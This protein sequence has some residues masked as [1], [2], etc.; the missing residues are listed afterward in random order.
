MRLLLL[1]VV[2]VVVAIVFL[3]EV[4]VVFLVVVAVLCLVVLVGDG[5]NEVDIFCCNTVWFV[6]IL[7]SLDGLRRTGTDGDGEGEGEGLDGGTG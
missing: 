2:L 5:S 6:E 4:A 7:T 1:V 3:V